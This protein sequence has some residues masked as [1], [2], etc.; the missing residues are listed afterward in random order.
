MIQANDLIKLQA[1]LADAMKSWLEKMGT[2]SKWESLNSYI[3]DHA[4]ELMASS[5]FNILLAQR[6]LNDYFK[7]NDMLKY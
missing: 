4:A 7:D 3:G 5:A 1:S 2:D 6:D